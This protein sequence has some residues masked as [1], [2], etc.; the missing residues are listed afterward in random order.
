MHGSF[1]QTNVATPGSRYARIKWP[2]DFPT[3]LAT[4]TT[5]GAYL[6]KPTVENECLI[7]VPGSHVMPARRADAAWV[8]VEVKPG[9]VICH[10]DTLYHA[11]G[12]PGRQ[13]R[14][15]RPHRQRVGDDTESVS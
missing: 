3:V 11:S 4:V 2:I 14:R 7:L 13:R 9:D 12:K 1:L 15:P 8:P 5:G 6:D 10:A